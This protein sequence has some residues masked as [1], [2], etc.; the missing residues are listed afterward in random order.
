MELAN[1]TARYELEGGQI[2]YN[3]HPQDRCAGRPCPVH[4]RTGHHMRAFPQ[5]FRA[6]RGF[7]ERICP[8][9][10]GHPDPDE[11]PPILYLAGIH[12]CDGCCVLPDDST[13]ATSAENTP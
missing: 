7:M 4:N 10:V 13:S 2:I 12:G 8:H 6:D 1:G 9:G 11:L 3:V 5:H